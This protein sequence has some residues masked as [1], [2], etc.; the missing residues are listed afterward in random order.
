MAKDPYLV[1]IDIGSSSIKLAV[2]KDVLNEQDKVQILAL[3]EGP[4]NGIKRGVITNMSEAT[5]SLIEVI[6]QAES[7]IGLPIRKSVVG[8]N[9]SGVSFINSEGLVIISRKENEVTE[10]DIER[11]MQDS[12]QKAFGLMNNEI[13][14]VIP[15]TFT[16]DNQSG[17]KYPVGMIANKLEAKT[18]IV[19]IET[20][21]LRNFTKVF[22][23]ANLDIYDRIYMPLASSDFAISLRQKKAG[24]VL[25][26]IGHYSTSFIV[27]ENEEVCGSGVIP[28]GSDHITAD[29]AVG[30][31]TSMEMAEEIKKQY[32]D[33]LVPRGGNE[34]DEED[35]D[36]EDLDSISE[37]E[38]FNPDLQINES[39]KI[40][41]IKEYAKLSYLFIVN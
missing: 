34:N 7:I 27:W 33:L 17:I 40:S 35:I 9:G 29:L 2:A 4:S 30:L 23:Q 11:V 31:Q 20:T 37:I 8:V 24:T 12:L 36:F 14:H 3:V 6:N 5:E 25:L 16:V 15:K 18:L 28:I 26:D 41:Q 1:A 32:L 38:M 13:L 10:L 21:H 22:S 39:F 19:S